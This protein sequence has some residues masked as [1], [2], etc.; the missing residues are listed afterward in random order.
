MIFFKNEIK[1]FLFFLLF[2]T[3][4]TI[5]F[6]A[7]AQEQHL[8]EGGRNDLSPDG[9]WVYFDRVV[10]RD[11]YEMEIY[12]IRVDG[13]QETCLTCSIKNLPAVIGQ[14]LAH[15]TGKGLLFQGLTHKAPLRP[16]A[17]Y[18]YHPSFGFN[19]DFYWLD[20]SKNTTK[21]VFDCSEAFGSRFGNACLHPQF[22]PDG[23]KLLFASR[24]QKGVAQN[25]WQWWTPAILNFDPVI[26][27]TSNL[28]IALQ[29]NKEAFYETHQMFDDGSFIYTFGAGR[30]PQEAYL[31]L[32]T[33]EKKTI[34]SP[35][36]GDWVEH[37]HRLPDGQIIL[38]TSHNVWTPVK[39]LKTLRMELHK[40]DNGLHGLKSSV[41]GIFRKYLLVYSCNNNDSYLYYCPLHFNSHQIRKIYLC[42]WRE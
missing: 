29:R 9:T 36:N 40:I 39:N 22:S 24:E 3:A 7:C 8:T 26:G 11:P 25:P 14:P 32:P 28:K 35:K 33:G 34:W 6:N 4:L 12:K 13:T 17:P 1:S 20:F 10:N 19:N 18:N 41:E 27:E 42:Y 21:M 16:R 38:N 5:N 2:I 15:P 23:T 31:Y 30:Y 37:A